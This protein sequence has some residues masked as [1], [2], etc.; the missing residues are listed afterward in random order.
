MKPTNASKVG[1]A[2]VGRRRG[3]VATEPDFRAIR[4]GVES[5]SAA[6]KLQPMFP[7]IAGIDSGSKCTRYSLKVPTHGWARPEQPCARGVEPDENKCRRSSVS[8]RL[9]YFAPGES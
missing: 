9:E 3:E 2:A 5:A 1:G 6:R 8:C 4:V 7:G